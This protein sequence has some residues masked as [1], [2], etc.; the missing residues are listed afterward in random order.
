MIQIVN[1]DVSV[2]GGI[3]NDTISTRGN[4]ARVIDAGDGDDQIYLFGPSS[5]TQSLTVT[6]FSAGA[7]GDILN[8]D[9]FG[10]YTD[11]GTLF[12]NGV[13]VLSQQGAD[14]HV[15]SFLDQTY[16]TVAVLKQ[17]TATDLTADN[18]GPAQTP[19]I[20]RAVFRDRTDANDVLIG[21]TDGDI[22]RGLAGDDSIAGLDGDDQLDG[23]AGDDT[24][25]GGAG[26]DRIDGG[27]GSD[28]LFGG[29]GN[30]RIFDTVSGGSAD[31]QGGDGDDYI[32]VD[33][34]SPRTYS[35]DPLGNY[36]I[37]ETPATA[38]ISA[39][40]GDDVI[41]VFSNGDL[42]SVVIDAGAGN[43]TVTITDGI[44]GATIT[45]GAG[46]DHIIVTRASY[47]TA[48]LVITDFAAG[49]TGDT[50]ELQGLVDRLT[51]Y[52][53]TGGNPYATGVLSLVQ[54]GADTLLTVS[55]GV[56][57]AVLV[58]FLDTQRGDFVDA[59][60][61]PA[62]PLDGSPIIGE[63]LTGT[64]SA[65]ELFGTLSDDTINGQAGN[66]LIDASAGNDRIFGGGGDDVISGGPGDDRLD[67]GAGSDDISGDAGAD[68]ITGGAGNDV[69]FGN[70]GDDRISGGDGDDVIDGGRGTNT[71]L[72][73]AGN[74]ELTIYGG[75]GASIFGGTGHDSI[76]SRS[77]GGAVQIDG[78]DGDDRIYVAVSDD[79]LLRLCR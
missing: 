64:A 62:L 33:I 67:G 28:T 13:L 78:G 43:D 38:S 53:W 37:T 14:T 59:N 73:D 32:S 17:T 79:F 47:G 50:L 24:I 5:Q 58:T 19:V 68:S 12:A 75:T 8:I 25:D 1:G 74:D 70:D 77:V 39:G 46:A 23:G 21:D 63:T 71:L 52:G 76:D 49:D 16:R 18:F 35:Y 69:L 41:D 40:D 42:T 44:N 3:G 72:G 27:T 2:T 11:S 15:L 34:E 54:S 4:G 10:Y 48:P 36:N 7:G 29:A 6:D 51:E 61:L 22:L 57:S 66:D 31:I 45:A 20:T 55:D 56:S 30:D 9:D 26:D 60:F 65:D